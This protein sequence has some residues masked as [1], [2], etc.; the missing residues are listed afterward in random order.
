MSALMQHTR[1]TASGR[2]PSVL[3]AVIFF[4]PIGSLGR[5]RFVVVL[6]RLGAHSLLHCELS[7][8]AGDARTCQVGPPG[9]QRNTRSRSSASPKSD[10]DEEWAARARGFWHRLRLDIL[11]STV[12]HK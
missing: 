8:A 11:S 1:S 4:A 2:V 9:G 10:I 5:R 12:F 6:L 7:P 3:H